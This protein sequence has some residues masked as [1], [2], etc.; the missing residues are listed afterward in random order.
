MTRFGKNSSLW[1]SFKVTGNSVQFVYYLVKLTKYGNF[2][3]ITLMGKLMNKIL[4]QSGKTGVDSE[5]CYKI[6]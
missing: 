1:G 5:S 3:E 2:F 4:K 6:I